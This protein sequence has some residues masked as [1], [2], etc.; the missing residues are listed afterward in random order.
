[1]QIEL[2][3]AAHNGIALQAECTVDG[4][5][6]Y[7]DPTDGEDKYYFAIKWG[8]NNDDAKN[9]ATVNI[10]YNNDP[11]SA[12][13]IANAKATYVMKRY[14]NVDLNGESLLEPVS[15]RFFY[16][17][18]E[19]DEIE[20]LAED[21][22][23]AHDGDVKAGVWF[24]TVGMDFEP[25]PTTVTPTAIIDAIELEDVSMGLP[26]SGVTYAQ[27]DNITSFSGGTYATGVGLGT[28]LQIKLGNISVV[29]ENGANKL[30]WNTL[31]ED[32]GDY[33]ILEKSLDGR[34]FEAIASVEGKGYASDY[35]YNDYNAKAGPNFYRIWYT[36]STGNR[37]QSDI[38]YV[39][40][41]DKANN[42]LSV[43]PNPVTDKVTVIIG[44][45]VKEGARL[46]ITDLQGRVLNEISNLS[47]AEQVL[48]FSK[49][50]Q[51]V[52]F[53][54]YSDGSR[55]ENVKVVKQ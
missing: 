34:T 54:K 47:Q 2:T 7:G 20:A 33:F 13:D 27:F 5:T 38:V 11:Y 18:S 29:H 31:K 43:H 4:W 45:E 23:S 14:W 21:F 30:R 36:E 28:P 17:Q 19:L 48:D 37:W 52:Y 25:G 53:I 46:Y 50:A 6:Y 10:T 8:E 9:A 42:F 3:T 41:D 24:K 39:M 51:G 55:E 12:E 49:L 35:T 15:V 26:L 22:A 1:M 16:E 40:V 44:G 32:A